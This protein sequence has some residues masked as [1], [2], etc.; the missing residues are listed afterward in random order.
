MFNKTVKMLQDGQNWQQKV[1]GREV[2][3]AV[4]V[5]G[6]FLVPPS[7]L[8]SCVRWVIL[9]ALWV[10]SKNSDDSSITVPLFFSKNSFMWPF[11]DNQLKTKRFVKANALCQIILSQRK[12]TDL[13][14][15]R[16]AGVQ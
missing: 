3:G 4:R 8:A 14:S 5:E 7:W 11:V 2:Q 9:L 16:S 12:H 6:H 15:H 13:D 10:F 1:L